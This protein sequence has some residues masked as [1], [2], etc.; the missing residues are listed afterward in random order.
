M[1]RHPT[2]A[3]PIRLCGNGKE[4]N[5][6]ATSLAARPQ[7]PSDD[8]AVVRWNK[9]WNCTAYT[10]AAIR[11]E[12]NPGGALWYTTQDPRLSGKNKI[13]PMTWDELLDR[14]G[15]RNWSSLELLD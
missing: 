5:Q 3:Q 14:I 4:E 1:A 11:G 8:A 9:V 6:V 10:Y 7:E 13:L 12:D 15:E 2:H